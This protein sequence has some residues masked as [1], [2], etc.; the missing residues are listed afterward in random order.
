[1]YLSEQLTPHSCIWRSARELRLQ[2]GPGHTK[3]PT[4]CYF[5]EIKFIC[6][7]EVHIKLFLWIFKKI[8]YFGYA[9]ISADQFQIILIMILTKK[10]H[11]P[12]KFR[13]VGNI[14]LSSSTDGIPYWMRIQ[15]EKTKFVHY[16][17]DHSPADIELLQQAYRRF[18]HT[19]PGTTLAI[20]C[21]KD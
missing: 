14:F 8:H 4:V 3:K 15:A 12:C 2:S 7:V 13:M 17:G 16:L 6:N 18:P 10:I 19:T 21:H 9:F 1:M 11:V 5:L 20:L